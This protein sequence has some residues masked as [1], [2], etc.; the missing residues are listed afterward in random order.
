MNLFRG[1]R[2]SREC[3]VNQISDLGDSIAQDLAMEI[4]DA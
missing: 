4:L 1:E 3:F 2:C